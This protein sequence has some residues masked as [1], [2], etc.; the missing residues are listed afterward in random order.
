MSDP[1][2]YAE[3]VLGVL[4]S[5]LTDCAAQYPALAKEFQRD[6]V[7]LSS[8]IEKHGVRFALDAMPA[9][10]KHFDVCLAKQL[11]TAS[12]LTHFGVDRHGGP[13]PRLFRGLVL[14]VFDR[15][16]VLKPDPDV[17][18]VR[19]L[20]QLLGV[21]R[22]LRMECS[23]KV[24]GN[25]VQD[26]IKIDQELRPSTFNWT[27]KDEILDADFDAVSF[28]DA[29]KTSTEP[30]LFTEVAPVPNPSYE[31]ADKLQRVADLITAELGTFV[32]GEWRFKHGPGAVAD[33]RYGSYKYEFK[34]WPA[35]LDEV[36][37]YDEFAHANLSSAI[38]H[39]WPCIGN[40][41]S[42]KEYPA[43]LHAVPKTITGPRLIASEPVALQWC[44]Q[45]IRDFMYTRVSETLISAFVDFRRQGK[46]GVLALEASR[47][48]S[49]ATI[50]LSSA[51]DRISCWHVER[52]FRRSPTIIHALWASRS[53]W[54]KQD[55]CKYS[56]R[57][58]VLR[59]FS[60]MGNAVTFPVQSLFFLSIALACVLHTRRMPITKSSIRSLGSS[61][62]RVFGDDIIVPND[63]A[64]LLV[65]TLHALGLRVNVHKTFTEGNF[66]ESCGVDAFMGHDVTCASVLDVP[67]R[68]GP[69]SIVSSVD[70]HNNFCERGYYHTAAF[71]QKTVS[72]LVSARIRFV[73]HGSG[74]FGWS[75]LFGVSD[76]NVRVRYNR[77][78]QVRQVLCLR[79]KT[80]TERRLPNTAA[81]L[82]QYFT[83]AAEV[84]TSAESTL[85][86]LVRRPK[87]G[88]ALGWV[89]SE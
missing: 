56:P 12:N 37:P 10:R 41:I 34:A 13:I 8:A 44:Q 22:K 48:G 20:R 35:R 86:Y 39:L 58:I 38:P 2:S 62:V 7:R 29:A 87:A 1:N 64:E 33:Q 61:E 75:D 66:R 53:M 31:L 67:K 70:V 73:A 46:N 74:L 32:P 36:F 77:H 52:L 24:R 14:R 26:F 17:Q 43:V 47:S 4:R 50:D 65:D 76:C 55:I 3:Y 84:V 30:S 45:A 28:T 59:K 80:K 25:A 19:L 79:Q 9:W 72:R 85:G 18:A 5:I 6:Y 88:L 49:H 11:L 21:V 54:L 57:H 51:S 15:S 83:E 78:R 89:D 68:T 42:D 81:G 69:R 27:H 23:V 63:C 16:G 60:T 82:L 40:G 71:I